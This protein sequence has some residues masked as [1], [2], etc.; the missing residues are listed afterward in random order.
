MELCA[1]RMKVKQTSQTTSPW[2][3]MLYSCQASQFSC[4]TASTST[5][6]Y[7]FMLLVAL[8]FLAHGQFL[9]KTTQEDSLGLLRWAL[10]RG[11]FQAPFKTA[12]HFQV[13]PNNWV[14]SQLSLTWYRW[15]MQGRRKPSKKTIS[16]GK[17]W[18][19]INTASLTHLFMDLSVWTSTGL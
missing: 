18:A 10:W 1:N 17:T 5:F 15:V 4:C 7:I 19:A 2:G 12:E 3:K 13:L 8:N 14:H 9:E 11:R 6:N 16:S